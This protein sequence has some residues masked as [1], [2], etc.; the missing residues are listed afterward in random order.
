MRF[1]RRDFSKGGRFRRGRTDDGRRLRLGDRL[2][3]P[4]PDVGGYCRPDD[5][6]DRDV[7]NQRSHLPG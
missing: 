3:G 7:H 2:R 4:G 5:A 6:G 1:S